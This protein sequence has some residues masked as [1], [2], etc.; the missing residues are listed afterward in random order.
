MRTSWVVGLGAGSFFFACGSEVVSS[1]AP[2]PDAGAD[3][4]SDSGSD[5]DGA[6][7]S[8]TP[9]ACTAAVAG[10]GPEAPNEKYYGYC[11]PKCGA[12][13]FC[14]TFSDVQMAEYDADAGDVWPQVFEAEP[15]LC[16]GCHPM[17][18]CKGDAP[19]ACLRAELPADVCDGAGSQCRVTDGG[20]VQFRCQ[21]ITQL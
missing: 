5:A 20:F 16:A 1:N 18:A 19:C 6:P 11:S 4:S 10:N 21:T 12:G 9:R 17:P 3:T 2:T 7:P 13:Q 8:H 14:F 15:L